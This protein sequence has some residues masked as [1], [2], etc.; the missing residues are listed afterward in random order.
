MSADKLKSNSSSHRGTHRSTLEAN[1]YH[2]TETVSLNTMERNKYV[3][4]INRLLK[5]YIKTHKMTIHQSKIDGATGERVLVF[6][7]R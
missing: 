4:S 5:K 1:V 3:R 2:R 7:L 6:V